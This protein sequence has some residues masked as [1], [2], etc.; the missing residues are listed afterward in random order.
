MEQGRSLRHVFKI[1]PIVICLVFLDV[2]APDDDGRSGCSCSDDAGVEV[3]DTGDTDGT[4]A[5]DQPHALTL[6]GT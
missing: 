2:A 3:D 5:T 4:G 6:E 1:L